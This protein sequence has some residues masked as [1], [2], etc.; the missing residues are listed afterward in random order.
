MLDFALLV[1]DNASRS[2]AYSAGV[3][4]ARS[5]VVLSL[6]PTIHKQLI[7]LF[8]PYQHKQLDFFIDDASD[9]KCFFSDTYRCELTFLLFVERY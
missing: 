5:R 9:V 6:F 4:D 8:V 2:T 3:Y 7:S 1:V